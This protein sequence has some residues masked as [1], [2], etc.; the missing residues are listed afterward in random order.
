MKHNLK[1]EHYTVQSYLSPFDKSSWIS[2][3]GIFFDPS[4]ILRFISVIKIAALS[5]SN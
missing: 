4:A 1:I 5:F 2:S 3:K